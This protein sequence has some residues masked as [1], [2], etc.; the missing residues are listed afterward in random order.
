MAQ[1]TTAHY[2]AILC[3]RRSATKQISFLEARTL[4]FGLRGS[5]YTRLGAPARG[6]QCP[7]FSRRNA[8]ETAFRILDS[9]IRA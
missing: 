1:Q 9:R 2:P 3:L 6:E 8:N 7:P 5:R 4:A